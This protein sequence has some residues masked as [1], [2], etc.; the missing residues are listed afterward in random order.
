MVLVGGRI[1]RRERCGEFQPVFDGAAGQ[2]R[3]GGEVGLAASE[4]RR[5]VP[6]SRSLN[7][8]AENT[9]R[10]ATMATESSAATA[11]VPRTIFVAVLM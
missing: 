8:Y 7:I 2:L 3:S 9:T 4:F 5:E 10:F 6:Q 1:Q 11:M